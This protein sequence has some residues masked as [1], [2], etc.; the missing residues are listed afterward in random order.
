MPL[1]V[2]ALMLLT[3]AAFADT[4]CS[5]SSNTTHACRDAVTGE[6]SRIDSLSGSGWT[7]HS[8]QNLEVPRSN[9]YLT[10]PLAGSQSRPMSEFTTDRQVEYSR[11]LEIRNQVLDIRINEL[12]LQDT[13]GRPQW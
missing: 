4:N 2:I 10:L 1:R 13:Y 3:Q 8:Q 7:V 12:Q 11:E 9:R 5:S 6:L